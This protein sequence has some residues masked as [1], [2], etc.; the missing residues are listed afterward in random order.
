MFANISQLLEMK[1]KA[2]ELKTKMES[3]SVTIETNG[4]T[5]DCNGNKKILAIHIPEEKCSDKT[6]LED[7]LCEAV[8]KAIQA[9]EKAALG[10]MMSMGGLQ[11]LTDMLAKK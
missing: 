9:A 3:I 10:D 6:R 11:G 1:K 7:E 2:E 4:I 5:V 8:N